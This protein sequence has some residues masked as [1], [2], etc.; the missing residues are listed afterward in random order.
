MKCMFVCG[1]RTQFFFD[2]FVHSLSFC[3]C[4]FVSLSLVSRASFSIS[5]VVLSLILPNRNKKRTSVRHDS[6][7]VYIPELWSVLFHY[8]STYNILLVVLSLALSDHHHHHHCIKI[9]YADSGFILEFEYAS[10][11]VSVCSCFV[12]FLLFVSFLNTTSISY[13]VFCFRLRSLEL[14]PSHVDITFILIFTLRVPDV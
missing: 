13:S 12:F 5:C 10:V 8:L 2:S 14:C 6:G 1:R 11:S 3:R 4:L 9:C 7:P